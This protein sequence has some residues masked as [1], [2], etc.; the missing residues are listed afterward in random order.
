MALLKA[1][2]GSGNLALLDEMFDTFLDWPVPTPRFTYAAM[3]L[4]LYEQG[5]KYVL[6]ISAPGFDPKEINVE[7]SGGTVL[8]TGE[9]NETTE[10]K[11][12]RYHRRE[13]R[14][15]SFSRTVTLPQDL[16]TKAVT[17]KLDKG[18]LKVELTPMNAL[19][20]KK[21]EVKPA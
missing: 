14:H 4:D 10:K 16:D 11:G 18:V 2:N 12:V 8:V 1:K 21:I 6:E 3:P 13:R 20:P 17:A 7:V 15:G 5:G 9:H 19:S